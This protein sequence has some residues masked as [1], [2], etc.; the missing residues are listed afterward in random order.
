MCIIIHITIRG[1]KCAHHTG[2]RWLSETTDDFI[3]PGNGIELPT[4]KY[5]HYHRGVFDIYLNL[6]LLSYLNT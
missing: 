1:H 6:A 3:P 2:C 4:P 5:C